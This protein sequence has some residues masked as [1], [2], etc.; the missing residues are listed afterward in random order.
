MRIKKQVMVLTHEDAPL[1]ETM[2]YFGCRLAPAKP[3]LFFGRAA[4]R[5]PRTKTAHA[6][7]DWFKDH[8]LTVCPL[9]FPAPHK[10]KIVASDSDFRKSSDTPC[11]DS[12]LYDSRFVHYQFSYLPTEGFCLSCFVCACA[13]LKEPVALDFAFSLARCFRGPTRRH[14]VEGAQRTHSHMHTF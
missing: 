11:E 2:P 3:N 8:L 13:D 14:D 12:A 10:N 4:K 9:S 7:F 6:V 5:E 1:E